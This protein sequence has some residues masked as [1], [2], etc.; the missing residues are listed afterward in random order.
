MQTSAV[1]PTSVGNYVLGRKIGTGAFATVW[2]ATHR[3]SNMKVAIKV[4][5]NSAFVCEE[6]RT[7]FVRELS[8]LKMTDHPF[9]AKLFE[10]VSTLDFTFVVM[11]FASNGSVLSYINEHG[12]MR[13][14]IARRVFLQLVLA[15]EYLHDVRHVAHRDLK[16]ENVLLDRNMNVRLIDFGVS[17]VFTPN[18]P[19]LLSECGSPAYAA[20]EMVSGS[21]YTKAA[22]LWSTG[23]LLYGMTVGRLPFETGGSMG[24]LVRAIVETEPVFPKQIP[25][26]IVELIRRLLEKDPKKRATISEVKNCAWFGGGECKEFIA[27]PFATDRQWLVGGMRHDIVERIAEMGIDVRTLPGSILRDEYTNDTAVY[28]MLRREE[29]TDGINEVIKAMKVTKKRQKIVK[30]KNGSAATGP[31]EDLNQMR[32]RM[33]R[34]YPGVVPKITE[35]VPRSTSIKR[36]RGGVGLITRPKIAIRGRL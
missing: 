35:A 32:L 9:I 17:N 23:V 5:D 10:V 8:I 20:P 2:E 1:I 21:P 31:K 19:E 24:E 13:E 27:L 33:F 7:F 25:A 22:D 12:R 14:K 34:D 18:S 28:Y 29:I 4:V 15:L 16:A 26:R 3:V 36:L 6:R 11:E 30:M